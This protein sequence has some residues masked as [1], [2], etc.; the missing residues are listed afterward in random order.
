MGWALKGFTEEVIMINYNPETVSTDYDV[1]DKLYFEELTLERVLDIAE[2]ENPRG[3]VVSVGGQIPNGLALKLSERGV[4][5]LGTDAKNIDIAEDR[6][7]FSSL[8]DELGIKQPDWNKFE[9]VSRAKEFAGKIG[10]PVLIRPSYVLSGSAMTVVFNEDEM[11]NYL[12]N[13]AAVSKEH[14][15]V[16]SKFMLEAREL[17]ADGV[18]D[19][20]NVFIGAI[21]EHIENAGVHSGDATMAIPTLSVSEI[22][23]SNIRD[24]TRKIATGLGIKGPFN[25]Q[26]I[27]KGDDIYVIECNLRASRSMPFVSKTAG[28]NLMELS[29]KALMGGK[30]S[31]GE[32]VPKKIGVKAPQFS[33]MRLEGADPVTGVEMVSTGEVACFGETF[34]EAFLKASMASG[35]DIPEDGKPILITVGPHKE[36]IIPIARKLSKKFRIFA[37]EH[38]AET[39]AESGIPCDIIYKI[40]EKKQPNILD[41]LVNKNLGM[42]I[43]IPNI[44][45]PHEEDMEKAKRVLQDE[46]LI[47][48]KAAEF[49]VPVI[50]NMELLKA[51]ADAIYYGGVEK[52]AEKI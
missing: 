6:Y 9:S 26:Y 41:Y 45:G 49:G 29:A 44:N 51:L 37:T 35:T 20:E 24:A 46:Y 50:T 27:A 42:V 30:I 47:R 40:G 12:M 31:G 18:C 5:I 48:R 1:L 23:K 7:K 3:I 38:T 11:E 10:Y 13:A 28:V 14:P 15:V 34:E 8:L 22:V 4:K 16:I 36:R 52:L 21:M 43:N 25:I 39:F 32:A 19:G 33:F 17:E 2:K